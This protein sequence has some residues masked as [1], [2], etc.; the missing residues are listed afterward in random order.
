MIARRRAEMADGATLLAGHDGLRVSPDD[1]AASLLVLYSPHVAQL[2]TEDVGWSFDRY[3]TWLADAIERL[4]L[5][6]QAA[7]NGQ[8]IVGPPPR[9]AQA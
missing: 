1:A 5:N 9:Q 2:L 7:N 4:I 8:E 3:Q 6:D